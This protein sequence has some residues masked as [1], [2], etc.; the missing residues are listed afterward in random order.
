L[1]GCAGAFI[2]LLMHPPEVPLPSKGRA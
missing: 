2:S 1:A